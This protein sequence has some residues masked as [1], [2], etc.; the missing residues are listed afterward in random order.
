MNRIGG[1]PIH[2][3]LEA[4]YEGRIYPVNPKYEE[5]AGL[6]CYPDLMAIPDDVDLCI[7]AVPAK[8]VL[9]VLERCAE[10]GVR[11]AV[12]F[13]S[14]FAEIGD[15]GRRAQEEMRLLARDSGMHV[16][17]PNCLGVLSYQSGLMASF[18]S[19][20]EAGNVSAGNVGFVCQSGAFGTYFLSLARSRGM[21]FSHWVATGNEA[22][23]STA[24]CVAYMALDPT[25]EVIAGYLEGVQDGPRFCEA[26]DLARSQ[27][28]PVV[29]LKAGR[30]EAGS[31]AAVSHTAS[32]AG[33]D[34]V[35]DAVFQ[36]YGVYRAADTDAL[37]NVTEAC[38][39]GALPAGDRVCLLTMSGGAGIIMADRASEIGLELPAPPKA[40]QRKLKDR[41]PYAAVT[42][43][44]DFTGHVVNEPGLMADFLRPIITTDEYD[45]ILTFMAHTLLSESIANE[46]VPD[47]VELAKRSKVPL[48]LSG[49]TSPRFEKLLHDN[50]L[51]II[52]NPS[53]TVD[54]IKALAQISRALKRDGREQA[55]GRTPAAPDGK[56]QRTVDRILTGAATGAADAD[57]RIVLGEGVS[58]AVLT[59]AE[60]PFARGGTAQNEEQAV[61]M[62]S[63]IGF[64]VVLKVDSPDIV[65]K[66]DV[67]G[68]AIGLDN[69]EQVRETF[70][71]ILRNVEARRPDAEVHGILVEEMLDDGIQVIVGAQRDPIFGPVVLFGM[72]GIYAEIF[73]DRQV[74]LAPLSVQDARQL[75][76]R[77]QAGRILAGQRGQPPYDVEALAE[78]LT[79][80][81]W[82]VAAEP[83]LLEV[84][85]NPLLVR[86][87]GQG[88]QALDAL[89]VL[90]S[91]ET[92]RGQ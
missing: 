35:F 60:M 69:E 76:A 78:V 40:I 52:D 8:Q 23:I 31:R 46:A 24:D 39:Y 87:R 44:V 34:A 72:G 38:S 16:L 57:G 12:V 89:V 27:G 92:S 33:N 64:P 86:T 48:F 59:E 41:L 84:D 65:H 62:A 2:Y 26:L 37:L 10:A 47:Y 82:A 88:V 29:M 14:G 53:Q 54:T 7:V 3:S 17:G 5:V 36:R 77:T 51:T 42:N 73:G 50:G 43:P 75:V 19:S 49:V 91:S 6:K 1:R 79:R 80:L 68:V 71:A 11:S 70:R 30:S 28:K 90:R 85:L 67:G 21:R 25:T 55:R 56:L 74:G 20:L 22:D 58:R 32:M 81:S 15:K 18:T 61:T 4:G 9:S 66:S 63:E 13:S 45:A 83:R